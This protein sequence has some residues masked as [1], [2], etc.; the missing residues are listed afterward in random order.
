M[1]RDAKQ[2]RCDDEE[3]KQDKPNEK[4]TQPDDKQHMIQRNLKAIKT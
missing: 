1:L 2:E 3:R 4:Q